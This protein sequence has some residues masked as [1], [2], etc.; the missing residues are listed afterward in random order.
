MTNLSGCGMF[1]IVMNMRYH[2]TSSKKEQR[3][4]CLISERGIAT[5]QEQAI[6]PF[7]MI[8]L[9]QGKFAL[10]D[11]A[12]FDWL[13][14]YPWHAKRYDRLWY[15]VN[16]YEIN[17]RRTTRRMH[18]MILNV[19][20]GKQTDHRNLNGL[21]NRRTN[22]RICTHGQNN[23]NR[24]V[25][26]NSAS[27]YKGVFRSGKKW[28]AAIKINYKKY[29]LGTFANEIDAAKVYDTAALELFGEFALLNFPESENK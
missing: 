16:S 1:V 4:D 29:H 3:A 26:R 24:R 12:D 14:K 17:G 20:K 2:N 5:I 22:L 25:C 13:N 18:R 9:T 19:P 11:A 23:Q 15:A 7:K 27:Q 28:S 8:S 10:V 6:R 21:D